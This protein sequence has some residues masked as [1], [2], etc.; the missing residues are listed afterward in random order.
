MKKYISLPLPIILSVSSLFVAASI[1]QGT[2][3][4]A[5]GYVDSNGVTTY[6]VPTEPQQSKS[7]MTQEININGSPENEQALSPEEQAAANKA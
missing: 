1:A 3:N 5:D 2:Q 7:Q 4:N 6:D